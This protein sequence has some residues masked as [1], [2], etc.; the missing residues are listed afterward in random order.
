MSSFG[1][2]VQMI[3]RLAGPSVS[4][5]LFAQGMSDGGLPILFH[6]A[7]LHRKHGGDLNDAQQ[8]EK[9]EREPSRPRSDVQLVSY[10]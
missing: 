3:V 4:S 10:V 2:W 7:Q 1:I 8:K 6:V 9:T 5:Q